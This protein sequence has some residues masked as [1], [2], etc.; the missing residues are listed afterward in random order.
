MSTPT[1]LIESLR[2]AVEGAAL[3]DGEG[4]LLAFNRALELVTGHDAE[5]L[6]GAPLLMICSEGNGLEPY[7]ALMAAVSAGE[8]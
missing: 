5:T 8:T 2:H 1:L 3:I 7:E 4:T 6:R